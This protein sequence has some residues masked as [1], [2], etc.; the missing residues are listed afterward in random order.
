[1]PQ[2]L[3]NNLNKPFLQWEYDKENDW[4]YL[5][6]IGFVS[7]EN[8]IK[9]ANLIL[10]VVRKEHYAYILNDNRQLLGPWDR[11]NDH[12]E[13]NWVPQVKEAGLQYFAHVLAP[14]VAGALS[15]QDLHRRTTDA[16]TMQIFGDVKKAEQWL[17][18]MQMQSYAL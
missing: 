3:L 4:L 15:A 18:N 7:H 14:N 12:L 2:E 16:F 6:W 8:I 13:C 11:S 17:K 10:E 5:N 9:G 1:M